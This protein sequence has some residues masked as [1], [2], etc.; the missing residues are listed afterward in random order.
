MFYDKEIKIDGEIFEEFRTKIDIKLWQLFAQME[1][2]GVREGKLT[3]TIGVELTPMNVADREALSP[4][5][6]YKVGYAL[7]VK[8]DETFNE[9]FA[10]DEVVHESG[11]FSLRPVIERDQQSIYDYMDPETGEIG[12]Y[13]E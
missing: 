6:N 12:G 2:Q 1:K 9:A 13:E 3:A 7:T 4:S 8:D 5:F 11:R 10:N